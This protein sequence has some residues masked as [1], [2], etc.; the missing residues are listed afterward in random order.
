LETE[1]QEPVAVA[2]RRNGAMRKGGTK[3]RG[4]IENGSGYNQDDHQ[5]SLTNETS[6]KACPTPADQG[7]AFAHHQQASD[8]PSQEETFGPNQRVPR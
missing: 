3:E 1:E 8:N 5:T 4:P 6:Y 7:A 2:A